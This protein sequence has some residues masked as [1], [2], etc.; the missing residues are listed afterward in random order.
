MALDE[1]PRARARWHAINLDQL[2]GRTCE[3]ASAGELR[4]TINQD[5]PL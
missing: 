1:L 4:K 5:Q 3:R 2:F